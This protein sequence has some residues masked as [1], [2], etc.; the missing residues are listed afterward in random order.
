MCEYDSKLVKL[1]ANDTPKAIFGLIIVSIIFIWAYMDYIPLEYLLL[2][3]LLQVLFTISRY[4]N[5]KIL[6]K[7]LEEENSDKLKKHTL[8]LSIIVVISAV[9][10]TGGTILGAIF[11]PSPYE[12]VGF[13]MI[14]GIIAAAIL[15]LTPLFNVFLAYFFIMILTQV[16]VMIYFGTHAHLAITAFL[17]I[18]MPVIVLLSKSIYNNHLVSISDN[19][20]L[21]SHVTELRELSIT[22]SLTKVYNRRHFFEA[23]QMLVSIAKRE[24]SEVSFLM[25]DIDYFKNINDTYGH[26]VGDYVLIKLSQ[27]IKSMVRNS[28]IFARIGGEEFAVLLHNTSLEGS[29]IIAEKIRLR[30]EEL[31]FEDNYI[32]FDLTISVGCSSLSE[33]MT[34]LE[35]L[36]Q[37]ADKKL[38]IAKELGRNRVQ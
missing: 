15:S 14:M 35:E 24:E 23:A 38:Y 34:T 11:A 6:L 2:W 18:Y 12:F 25:I 16:A 19:N 5:G 9:I 20:I 3:S 33:S 10:W 21:E 36:Y 30:V 27:E 29:K 13:A 31:D 28:D 1:V 7:Y 22:D 37:D 26:Q 8:F 4:V 32:P 17:L